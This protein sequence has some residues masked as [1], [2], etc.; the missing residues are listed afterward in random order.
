MPSSSS[1]KKVA[2]VAARSG[3]GNPSGAAAAKNRNWLFAT[4]IVAIVIL[5]LG[6]V[7]VARNTFS[8]S[9]D[10]T[11][12]PRAN[13]SDGKPFDHWHAAFAMNVCGKELPPLAQPA[14]DPLG[15]HTHGDGL[16]HIHPFTVNASGHRATMKKFWDLVGLKVTDDGFKDPATKKVYKAG[17]TTCGGKP[18]ELVMAYWK[19]AQTASSTKPDKIITSGFSGT[20]FTKGLSAYT[21]A[22]VPKGTRD[23]P[24][25]SSAAQAA[26]LGQADGGTSSGNAPQQDS[27]TPATVPDTTPV[28]TSKSGSGG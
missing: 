18:T 7:V 20:Y 2:R 17:E 19:D 22:L 12:H 8:D 6:V 9:Q 21:L 24:A 1:A 16:I 25:P 3:S 4:A 26:Q 14:T 23:I 28:T 5:G 15:I 13:L 27:G 11:T 10:N